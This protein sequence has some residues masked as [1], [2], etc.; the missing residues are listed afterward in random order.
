MK[1][2]TIEEIQGWDRFYRANF[3][4]S[5]SGFK[6]VSLIAS[7]NEQGQVNLAIFSNIVH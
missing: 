5:L 2:F 4:N 3:V 6:P 1:H 7:Q